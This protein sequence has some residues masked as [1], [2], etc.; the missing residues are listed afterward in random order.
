MVITPGGG[1]SFSENC[2]YTINANP[3]SD[4]IQK[5]MMIFK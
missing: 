4:R 1:Y 2:A 3:M 5:I